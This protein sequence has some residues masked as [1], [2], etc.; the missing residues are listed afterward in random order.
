[1]DEIAQFNISRWEALVKANA[2][3]ARAVPV[4]RRPKRPRTR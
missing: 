1:M 4:A 2:P 3:F